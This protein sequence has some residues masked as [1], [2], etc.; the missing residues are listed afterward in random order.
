MRFLLPLIALLGFSLNAAAQCGT[1]TPDTSCVLTPAFPTL[2]PETLP[3]ATA[4]EFY[5]T[6]IH[7]YLPSEFFEPDAGLDVQFLQ[8]QVTG[9]TG[10]PFGLSVELNQPNGLYI[11]SENEHGCARI[12]GTPLSAGNFTININIVATVFVP[13]FGIELNQPQ[14]FTLD[15][16]VLPGSGGNFSF[17]FDTNVGCDSAVVQFEG[18]LNASPN[19]TSWSW[20]FGNGETSDQQVPPAQLF[21]DTGTYEVTLETTFYQFV[22]TEVHVLSVNDNWCGDIEEPTCSGLFGILPDIYVQIRDANSNL[23]YQSPSTSNTLTGSWTGLTVIAN[24]GPYTIQVW[25][26]DL[27]SADDD[28][29]IFAFDISGPGVINFSEPTGTAGFLVVDISPTEVF[30]NTETITV[31]PAPHPVVTQSGNNLVVNEDST[32]IAYTWYFNGSVIPGGTESSLFNPAPGVYHVEV[33]NGFGCSNMSAPFILCPNPALN[34][35]A[36]TGLLST[37]GNYSSYQ[38]YYE[39]NPI[40]GATQSFFTVSEFG[41]YSLF[42]TTDYGCEVMSDSLLVCPAVS[43]TVGADGAT[44]SVPDMFETY[45]WVFNGIPVQGANGPVLVTETAGNY[46]VI[47]T[48]DYGCTITSSIAQST[49]S[50]QEHKLSPAQFTLFPNPA[51]EGFNLRTHTELDRDVEITLIDLQGR[52]VRNYGQLN[53]HNLNYQYFSLEGIATGT[54]LVVL[55]HEEGRASLR[56]VVF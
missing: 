24:N 44:L 50:V 53:R 4:G 12:C 5:E 37:P 28:L 13:S 30:T 11:P 43:I 47:V 42:I 6:D 51:R 33:Q 36:S 29:G 32:F 41:W 35:N 31:F 46:W 10:L 27:I 49:V 34:Y 38:W 19:P 40:S 25:D 39:G 17:I 23:I 45:Q 52:L 21:P 8:V 26:E 3:D 18:L 14:A 54:Y 48:T 56:I 15:L 20:D 16:T 22:I 1:C 7:F 55:T 2:C 9:T